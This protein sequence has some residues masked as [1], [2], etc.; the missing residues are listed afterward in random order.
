MIDEIEYCEFGIYVLTIV[1]LFC[2]KVPVLSEH[3]IEHEP[4]DSTA[5]SDFTI[6]LCLAIFWIPIAKIIELNATSPSGIAATAKEIPLIK[7]VDQKI[8]F[9]KLCFAKAW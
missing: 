8:G 2:V 3:I 4:N 6:A 9:A 1:I 7:V 5:I